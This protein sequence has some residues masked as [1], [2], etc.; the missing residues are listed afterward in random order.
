MSRAPRRV[1]VVGASAG[2]GRSLAVSLGRR[3][4][5]VA[6]TARRAGLLAD[7]VAEAGPTATGVVGDATDGDACRILVAGAA[8]ALGGLDAVVY[9]AGASPL[10]PVATTS[11]AAW[12]QVLATNVVGAALTV[13]AAAHHLREGRD[14]VCVLLSSHSVDRPWP[15]LVPYAVSKAGLD[16]LAV[17]LRAEEPWLRVVRVVVGPTATSF[18]DRWEPDTAGAYFERWAADGYLDHQVLEPGDVASRIL[19][20]LDGSD[21]SDE[22]DAV[23]EHLAGHG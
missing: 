8:A 13:S 9:A 10:G 18:A 6:L 23:G 7:A 11:A 20:V 12:Q 5:H 1:L 15:G 16:A 21:R 14:P 19:A 2:I 3:G 17:G 22:V 4:D